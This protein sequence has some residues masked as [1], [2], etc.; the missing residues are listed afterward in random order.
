[1]V[2]AVPR[3][4]ASLTVFTACTIAIITACS[5]SAAPPM[6]S[7]DPSTIRASAAALP[8]VNAVVR[9]LPGLDGAHPRGIDEFDEV[10]GS[11]AANVPFYWSPSL[12]LVLLPH[13]GFAT[14][15]AVTIN[16]HGAMSGTLG[17]S[18]AIVWMPLH[19]G[20]FRVFP[21]SASQSCS[22]SVLTWGGQLIGTCVATNRTVYGTTYN[23]H[24][25]PTQSSGYEYNDLPA[26]VI[27]S[28]RKTTMV[29]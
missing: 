24:G 13:P 10:V 29:C 23:W 3:R 4:S 25:A 26:T 9:V 1:M 14:G 21:S 19:T 7:S 15:Q 27:S 28:G 8:V 17:G 16:D 22:A 12:G 2:S 5:D 18:T 11:T 20:Q 6:A